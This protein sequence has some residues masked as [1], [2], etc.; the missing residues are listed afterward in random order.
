M[1]FSLR[2]QSFIKSSKI[3]EHSGISIYAGLIRFD[4]YRLEAI[5]FKI[6]GYPVLGLIVVCE[7]NKAKFT[8]CN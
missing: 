2:Q 7:K 5:R 6:L 3:R 4:V 1:E 8:A